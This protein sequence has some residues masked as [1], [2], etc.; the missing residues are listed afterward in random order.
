LA[1]LKSLDLAA[2]G[3]S[4]VVP[5]TL[6]GLAHLSELALSYNSGLAG[7]LP[8]ALRDLGLESLLAGG[9]D[10]C[11]PRER[12][13]EE[14]LAAIPK[15]RIVLCGQP[16]AA[17]LVQAVQSRE[18]PVPLVAGEDALLRVFVTAA[19]ETT[20]GI[21]EVRTR[22]YLD[23][24]ERHVVDISGSSAP[25]PTEIDEGDL[26]KSA[27]TEIPG[28][29]VQPGLEMVVE[30]DPGNVLDPGLGVPKR[31]P[32]EGRLAVEVREM[33]TLDLTVIPFL[34]NSDP[35][36]A[37][38][39]LVDDMAAD[40][41]G[42]HLL[43]ATHVLLPVADID[44]TA[45]APVASN[46]NNAFDLLRQTNAIRVLE[47]GGGHYMGM[48]SGELTGRSGLAVVSGRSI[49]SVPNASIIAHELGH[50]M[51]LGHAPCGGPGGLDLSFPDP[52]GAIGA[53]GYDF[54]L[55][56]LVP[57]RRKDHM[58][59]CDPTWT[60]DY[61][62]TNALGHRLLDEG[63]SAAALAAAPVRSLLLWGGVDTTGTP[64]LNPAFVADAPP[65]L[66]DSA[67]D[68]TVTG[69]DANGRELFSLSFAMPVALSEEA[70]VS[71]FVF[72][73]PARP[74]W[75]DALANVTLSGP[76]GTT[77]L[78]GDSN[79]PMAILRNPVTGR[80]RGFL[81]G[82]AGPGAAQAAMDAA[83]G[84]AGR[85]RADVLFS[86]G[87]PDASAWRR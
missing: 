77:T 54:R 57:D 33:P 28:Q 48:M 34:W 69:R 75:A 19:T 9:T 67:G 63:T 50:N 7:A 8:A 80:V 26:A 58:S 22:F 2:N 16:P 15:R 42:H 4:G 30:I 66:P 73:L 32:E 49:F 85:G 56:R 86:R 71:S 52:V 40:P 44:V 25:I 23:G 64:F 43:D 83:A 6:G 36:S 87:I 18:H 68:Y 14:W 72:A 74:G 38:I 3:L 12:A 82:V 24:S 62:F 31:I 46:S 21:P 55:G 17:Y 76:A 78:D 45:H 51:G 13:F 5:P 47:G 35:D 53:W 65:A 81:R 11:V 39:G 61:H 27:N 79:M 20:E 84:A 60:S 1:N 37:I 29:I 70:E 41:G 10:L 59:Y